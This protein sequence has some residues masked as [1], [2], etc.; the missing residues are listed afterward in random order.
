[1]PIKKRYFYKVYADNKF[2]GN[3]PS[4]VQVGKKIGISVI[5]ATLIFKEVNTVYSD[6][7]K[8]TKEYYPD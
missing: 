2:V 5:T 4:L 6:K 1:M 8:I 7:Y 3:Y